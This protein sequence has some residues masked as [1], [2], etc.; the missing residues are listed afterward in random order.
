MDA[1]PLGQ[2]CL[3][4]TERDLSRGEVADALW[5]RPAL[6]ESVQLRSRALRLKVRVATDHDRGFFPA[7]LPGFT[8]DP[9]TGRW[10]ALRGVN[11]TLGLPV[12]RRSVTPAPPWTLGA[13]A[14]PKRRA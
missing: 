4:A 1:P 12:I 3:T 13:P 2:D 6:M 9:Q 11:V 14:E 7:R 5:A 8:V 10:V